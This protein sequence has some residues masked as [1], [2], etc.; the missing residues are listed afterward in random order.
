[1]TILKEIEEE[2]DFIQFFG[3]FIKLKEEAANQEQVLEIE[4]ESDHGNCEYKLKFD[5]DKLDMDRVE[6]LQT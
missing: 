3:K 1:M 5:I 6:H 2:D 4:E